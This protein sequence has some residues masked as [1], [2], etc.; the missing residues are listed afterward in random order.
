MPTFIGVK[1]KDNAADVMV[2]AKETSAQAIADSSRGDRGEF[3]PI[4]VNSCDYSHT[5]KRRCRASIYG[6]LLVTDIGALSA[7][8]ESSLIYIGN[9]KPKI[10]EIGSDA[11][12]WTDYSAHPAT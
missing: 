1:V 6:Q 12:L 8:N 10:N 3:M 7:I 4:L 5:L 11:L 2:L 9:P